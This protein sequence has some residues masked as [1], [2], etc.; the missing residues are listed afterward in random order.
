MAAVMSGVV[1]VL[2]FTVGL[3]FGSGTAHGLADRCADFGCLE[4]GREVTSRLSRWARPYPGSSEV[5]MLQK[6]GI[7]L[8]LAPYHA[9]RD[10]RVR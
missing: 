4:G 5:V 6:G 8:V 2:S 3:F 7:G 10:C 9:S 1:E